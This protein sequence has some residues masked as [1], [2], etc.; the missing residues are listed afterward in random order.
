M[1][2]SKKLFLFIIADK[3]VTLL[4]LFG[5]K[6]HFRTVNTEFFVFI[7]S[8]LQL[9]FVIVDAN[10]C[11]MTK[12]VIVIDLIITIVE[13]MSENDKFDLSVC[14]CLSRNRFLGA[15]S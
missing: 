5:T 14:S 1:F 6:P 2:V 12:N 11:R 10:A 4:S 13:R 8:I 9:L 3:L 15:Q 7:R